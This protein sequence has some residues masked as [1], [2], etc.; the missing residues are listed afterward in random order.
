MLEL[1]IQ[2]LR[3]EITVLR[4]AIDT[5]SAVMLGATHAMLPGK[6]EIA[7]VREPEQAV[8]ATAAQEAPKPVSAPTVDDLQ[9]ICTEMCRKEPAMKP[10][11]KELIAS[12]DGAKTLNKVPTNRLSE[13]K[14]ALEALQ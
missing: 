6:V 5:F 2:K 1:E 10:R 7:T 13:L 9:A 4:S 8:E 12:F 11:I 14:A 3:E